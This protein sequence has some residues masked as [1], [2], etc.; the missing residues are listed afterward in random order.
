[1]SEMYSTYDSTN[2]AEVAFA[3]CFTNFRIIQVKKRKMKSR[4][5]SKRP[6]N[7]PYQE[8]LTPF[9]ATKNRACRIAD[10]NSECDSRAQK[11][12]AG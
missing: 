8:R 9:V 12:A 5:H 6:G 7:G 3:A 1:M 4:D 10:L 2:R 11:R